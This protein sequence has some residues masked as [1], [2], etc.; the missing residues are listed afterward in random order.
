MDL[1]A[2]NV[3]KRFWPKVKKGSIDECWL[4]QAARIPTGYGMMGTSP[5]SKIRGAHRVSWTI[6]RGP[7]P[8]GMSVCHTCD[9]PACV[10]PNHLF[11]GTHKENMQDAQRKGRMA[12]RVMDA[13]AVEKAKSLHRSG[14][15]YRAMSKMMGVHPSV[16]HRYV[17]GKTYR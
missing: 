1:L 12:Q 17:T 16:I 11:L 5:S 6:H 15:S 14:M 3:E 13:E 2:N 10:N 4:W 8:Q 9:V 7:I